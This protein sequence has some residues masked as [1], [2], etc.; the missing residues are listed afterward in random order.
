MNDGFAIFL[1]IFAAIVIGGFAYFSGLEVGGLVVLPAFLCMLAVYYAVSGPS[2]VMIFLRAVFA[3][4]PVGTVTGFLVLLVLQ[5]DWLTDSSRRAL[6][7]AVVV[8]G[9]WVVAFII[10]EWRRVTAERERRS[11]LA[12]AAIAEISIIERQAK[13]VD[14]NDV[15]DRVTREFKKRARY[16]AFIT[17]GH[18]YSTLSRVM[19][20]VEI[21]E[22]HQIEAVVWLFQL[23]SRIDRMEEH[24]M[25]ETFHSLPMVRRK[26]GLVRFLKLHA[27]VGD[28][29]E[30]ANTAL[31]NGRFQGYLE[32]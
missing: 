11:D 6:A 16:R 31:K 28:A 17:Y 18:E 23:L 4:V 1:A 26:E 12:I 25:G 30:S 9:G 22:E 15:I 7:S 3:L 19:E 5:W 14:W 21:L 27:A 13:A 29:A 24:I 20:Q 2:V 8:A 10:G 32:I